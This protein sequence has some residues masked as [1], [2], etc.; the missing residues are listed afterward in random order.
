M[1]QIHEFIELQF[2]MSQKG[3]VERWAFFF[4]PIFGGRVKH[5]LSICKLPIII[6]QDDQIGRVL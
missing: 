4:F 6:M 3:N 1:G 5:A 2:L